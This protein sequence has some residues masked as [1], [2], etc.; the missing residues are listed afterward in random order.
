MTPAT[1]TLPRLDAKLVASR[2]VSGDVELPPPAM[3]SLPESVVQFGTG[4]F[5]RGFVDYF[6]DAAIR[7]GL[8]SGRVVAVGSTGSGRDEALNTQ[9][10]LYTI[11]V[12]DAAH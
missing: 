11:V 6:V 5:L 7:Q 1:S 3:V 12:E 4:A 10:G 8:Y 2:S 9:Q